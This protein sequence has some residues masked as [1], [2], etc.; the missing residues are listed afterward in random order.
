MASSLL[1]F[2]AVEVGWIVTEVGRQPWV[3]QGVMKTAAG[4]SP[5]LTA[6]EATFTLLG[7]ATGY[8]LLLG[9]Y[10]YVV[11]RIIRA[12][13]PARDDLELSDHAESS[14]SEVTTSG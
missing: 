10:T 7:F 1:G 13:P 6:T 5:G 8:A 4:V 9:L 2:V 3:I 12:G 14:T 11:G